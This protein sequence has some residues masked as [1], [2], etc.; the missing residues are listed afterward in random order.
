MTNPS[1]DV[2]ICGAEVVA[3]WSEPVDVTGGCGCGQV[4]FRVRGRMRQP[5]ACH[6]QQCQRT[7]G[8]YLAATQ[9]RDGDLAIDGLAFVT[10][11]QS[12]PTARRGFCSICGSNLF[13]KPD[14]V[15][16]TSIMMG[17]LDRP[18][19][20][21]LRLALHIHCADKASYYQI[22]ADGVPRRNVS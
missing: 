18:H 22:G 7:S 3:G 19:P 6:C 11:F 2:S 5:I 12:S 4:R 9:A 20:S 1:C 16:R 8:H 14:G 13:W 15:E 21:Q 17:A 10:W